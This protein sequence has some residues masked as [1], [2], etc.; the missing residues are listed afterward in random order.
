MSSY[1]Q[2]E[3]QL[4]AELIV[5]ECETALEDDPPFECRAA[6]GRIKRQAQ[7]LVS[8]VQRAELEGEDALAEADQPQ[9]QQA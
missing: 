6:I 1:V 4:A 8:A 7:S 3:V 9:T 2:T 5:E